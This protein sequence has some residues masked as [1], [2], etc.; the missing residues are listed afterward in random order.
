MDGVFWYILICFCI[1]FVFKKP[2]SPPKQAEERFCTKCVISVYRQI[3]RAYDLESDA[4]LPTGYKMQVIFP[5]HTI[6][7]L[8]E[9][10]NEEKEVWLKVCGMT[11]AGYEYVGWIKRST[12]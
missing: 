1:C 3:A 6:L 4:Y 10:R 8:M 11:T 5:A 12:L 9:V 2:S 7:Y